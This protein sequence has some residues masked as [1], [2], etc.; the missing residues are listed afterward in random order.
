MVEQ[1]KIAEVWYVDENTLKHGKKVIS[2]VDYDGME[3]AILKSQRKYQFAEMLIKDEDDIYWSLGI[4]P[5]RFGDF[6]NTKIPENKQ[7]CDRIKNIYETFDFKKYFERK[8]NDNKYLNK[9]E[10]KYIAKEHPDILSKAKQSRE[11][12]LQQKKIEEEK[13]KNRVQKQNQ[14]K[15]KRI[16]SKFVEKIEKIKLEIRMGQRVS[17][18]DLKFYKDSKYENGLTSQNCFLYLAKQYGIDIPIATQGF[19]NN[20]LVSYD[21]GNGN[22]LYNITKNKRPSIKIH[23]YLSEIYTKVNEEFKRE[24]SQTQILKKVKEAK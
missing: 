14:E 15:V 4:A 8:I 3:V 12:F 16:N 24:K 17:N 23:E 18:Q 6:I 2:K 22:Y 5:I 21:F 20:R 19:I 10:L 7:Y 11:N 9:C 13:E 1:N